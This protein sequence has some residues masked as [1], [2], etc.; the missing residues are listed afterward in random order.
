MKK[1]PNIMMNFGMFTDEGN[2]KV[3]SI[4]NW[5]SNN[6]ALTSP[7]FVVQNLRDLARYDFEKYGEATDTVVREEVLAAVFPEMFK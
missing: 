6:K 5:H 2:L 4:V 1:E 3:L 7:E